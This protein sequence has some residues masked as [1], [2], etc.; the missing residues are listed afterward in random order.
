[1]QHL[2][3]FEQ[4]V[5][6]AALRLDADAYGVTIRQEIEAHGGRR[7]KYCQLTAAGAAALQNAYGRVRDMADGVLGDLALRA[8]GGDDE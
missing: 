6:F 1:M 4:V 7:R 3:E 8:E 2:G 5:L